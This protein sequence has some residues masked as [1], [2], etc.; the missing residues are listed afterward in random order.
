M[1]CAKYA[2]PNLTPMPKP[3]PTKHDI[4]SEIDR[5]L[6]MRKQVYA[7]QIR[8]KKM[9]RRQADEQM[10]RLK[11]ARSVIA[12]LDA[13]N[14]ERMLWEMDANLQTPSLF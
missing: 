8:W 7:Q 12:Y 13:D 9:T 10:E 14:L 2:N 3:F 6:A 4:L 11:A 1:A 5:E